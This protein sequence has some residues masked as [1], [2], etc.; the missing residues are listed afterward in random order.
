VAYDVPYAP[1]QVYALLLRDHG[2]RVY[3]E[4][5]RIGIRVRRWPLW[6]QLGHVGGD[7]SV[8]PRGGGSRVDLTIRMLLPAQ[9]LAVL[10]GLVFL[11]FGLVALGF[12]VAFTDVRP[13]VAGVVAVATPLLNGVWYRAEAR[14]VREFVEGVLGTR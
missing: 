10:G 6:P 8:L 1:D 5:D 14:E 11:A 9:G 12:A 13:L 4:Q 3:V 7:V 2:R